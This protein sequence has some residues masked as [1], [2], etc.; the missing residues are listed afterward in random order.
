MEQWKKSQLTQL[1][2]TNDMDTAYKIAL[3]FVKN[4]GF[5]FFAFSTTYQTPNGQLDIVRRN[6]YPLGWN[7]K[8]EQKKWRVIDPVVAHCNRSMLPI[9]WSE[10]LFSKI[11][12]LWTALEAQGIQH[13]WSQSLHDEE[14]G[15]C[16]ILSLARSH[17][18]I[19]VFEL[20]ENLGFTVFM[21]RHL[22]ALAARSLPQKPPTQSAALLSDREIDVL[23]LAAAGMT[24]D[25]SAKV[26]SLSPRTV[27]FHMQNTIVKFKVH[28][29][30]A[31]IIAAIKEGYLDGAPGTR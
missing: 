30:I 20:Y 17:C 6:N 21:A 22:H 5:K 13:G 29:K 12:S 9:V 31:A 28:N 14:S 2:S 10:Q 11:P 23:K 27:H 26:L 8:Y 3:G 24:A 7:K 1:S 15:L 18:E 4:I 25:E 19:S 16:T